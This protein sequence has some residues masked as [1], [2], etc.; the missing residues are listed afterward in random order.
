MGVCVGLHAFLIPEGLQAKPLTITS[1]VD[2]LA[3]MEHQVSPETKVVFL[4]D[5]A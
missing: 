4:V 5:L 2:L 3:V 1:A